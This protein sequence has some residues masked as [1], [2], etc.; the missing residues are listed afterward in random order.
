MIAVYVSIYLLIP[1]CIFKK[2]YLL[3]ILAVTCLLI[4]TA[5]CNYFIALLTAG[6][7]N[8]SKE[9]ESLYMYTWT[10]AFVK[11]FQ[12]G[13]TLLSIAVSI[14]LGKYWYLKQLENKNLSAIKIENEKKIL[15]FNI[16]PDFLLYSLSNLRRKME[17]SY[18]DSAE[19]ILNLSDLFSFI[20]YDCKEEL[21]PL[22][23]EISAIKNLITVEK[24]IHNNEVEIDLSVD[25]TN[26]YPLT[27]PLLLFSFL[28]KLFAE[29]EIK[30]KKFNRININIRAVDEI[31]NLTFTLSCFNKI[32]ID[33]IQQDLND[34]EKKLYALY[35]KFQIIRNEK[36][37][38][39]TINISTFLY[40]QKKVEA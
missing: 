20:L 16:R 19:M 27:P 33:F 30:N 15:K 22:E 24:I 32:A 39:Y 5:Y 12:N 26:C 17:T 6:L 18:S 36:E 11:G 40:A 14:K 21:I 34:T 25:I 23:K 2:K 7:L 4:L 1:W 13:V 3:F 37:N 35:N 31:L 29:N 9:G 28:Q 8:I 38:N 10:R